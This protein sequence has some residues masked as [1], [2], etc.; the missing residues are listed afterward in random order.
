[1]GGSVERMAFWGKNCAKWAMSSGVMELR[2]VRPEECCHL[3]V[4]RSRRLAA[5]LE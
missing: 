3:L 2:D 1:M 4:Q 5:V